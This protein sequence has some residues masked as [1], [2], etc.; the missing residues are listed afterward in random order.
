MR[1]KKA[2]IYAKIDRVGKT[3]LV[4]S[5]NMLDIQK[6]NAKWISRMKNV[7]FVHRNTD[8]SIFRIDQI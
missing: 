1:E 8:L 7:Q 3:D 2:E 5:A 6:M 4:V